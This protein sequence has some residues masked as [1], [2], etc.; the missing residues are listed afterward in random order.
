MVM[1][2]IVSV[3]L[4]TDLESHLV[5]IVQGLE[6]NYMDKPIHIE[7]VED[8]IFTHLCGGS[9]GERETDDLRRSSWDG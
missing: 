7:I 5:R 2:T 3:E 6:M 1:T 4:L 8:T 9:M